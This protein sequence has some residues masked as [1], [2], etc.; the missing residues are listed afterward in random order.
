MARTIYFTT[1][2][3]ATR[4]RPVAPDTEEDGTI[5]EYDDE[6][7]EVEV[8]VG[9]DVEEDGRVGDDLYITPEGFELTDAEVEL[10]VEC[11]AD[12]ARAAERRG[13][14]EA[15]PRPNYREPDP[16]FLYE[17][18]RDRKMGL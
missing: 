7:Y 2:I 9:A 16:D 14:F 15:R 8:T 3:T 5:V 10:A 18:Y 12:L 1:T 11:L 13:E 17:C 6:E 4:T